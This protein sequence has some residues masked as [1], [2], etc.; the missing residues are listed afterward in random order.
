MKLRS[1]AHYA[2][3]FCIDCCKF[4]SGGC[5]FVAACL[6]RYLRQC[7]VANPSD[8]YVQYV[9]SLWRSFTLT[10]CHDRTEL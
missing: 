9:R 10:H 1:W 4:Y 3:Y 5:T 8:I 7:S 2:H 6:V